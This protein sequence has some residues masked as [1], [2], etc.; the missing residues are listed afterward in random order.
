MA[1]SRNFDEDQ[2]L[3]RAVALFRERGYDGTSLP[4]L[5]A[6]LGICRQSLYNTFGD[7][8]GLYLKA[9]ERWGQL[10]VDSKLDLLTRQGSPLEN[11]RTFIRGFAAMAA[12]CPGD[13]CF[14]VTAMV[15]TRDDPEALAVVERQVARLERGIRTALE[16]A[17][18]CGELR[19]DLRPE[20]LAR[21]LIT[22]SYGMGLLTRLPSSGPRIADTVSVLLEFL[23]DATPN[24]E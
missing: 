8:R 15:E 18:D 13:G 12:T 17:R 24:I 6:K 20:R 21:T 10:E 19:H 22:A 1:R 2:V 9:L 16:R 5:T 23:D 14:T 4:A 3:E 7:K 11:L